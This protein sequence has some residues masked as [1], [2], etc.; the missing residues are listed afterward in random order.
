[1]GRLTEYAEEGDGGAGG[2]QGEEEKELE[3]TRTS[4]V[5]FVTPDLKSGLSP[6]LR[7]YRAIKCV[8]LPTHSMFPT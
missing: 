6:N 4:S 2:A 8:S 3:P 1:M 5:A 7:T